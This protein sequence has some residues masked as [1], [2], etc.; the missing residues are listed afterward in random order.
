MRRAAKV[1]DSHQR[2]VAA[3]RAHGFSVFSTAAVSDGFPDAVAGFGGR[4][5]LLEFKDGEKPPSAR[6]LTPAQVKFKDEWKGDYTLIE[7][8]Q[9]IEHFVAQVKYDLKEWK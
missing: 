7:T 4:T 5:F 6:K 9:D 2:F 3:L 8:L 1:D